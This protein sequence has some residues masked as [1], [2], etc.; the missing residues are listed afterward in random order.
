MV[1]V[2]PALATEVEMPAPLLGSQPMAVDPAE[3]RVSPRCDTDLMVEPRG[4][5]FPETSPSDEF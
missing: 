1:D 5:V 4:G 3:S 2:A